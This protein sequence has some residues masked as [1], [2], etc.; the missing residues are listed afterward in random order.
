MKI[1]GKKRREIREALVEAFPMP[2]NLRMVTD[3]VLDVPLQNVTGINNDME[4][5]AFDLIG[6]VSARGRLTELVIGA[7][8]VN[9]DAPKLKTLAAQFQ[10]AQA[11]P[12]EVERINLD[13]VP[14]QNVGQWLEMFARLRRRVCRVERQPPPNTDG[15]GTGFLVAPDVAMTN[16]HVVEPFLTSGAD[17]VRMRFDYET[18]ID[19]VTVSSGRECPLAGSWRLIDSPVKELDFA[20][21]RLAVPAGDDVVAGRKRGTLKPTRHTFQKGHPLIILQHPEAKPL[22]LAIGSV[23]DPDATPNRVSYTVNTEPGSSGSPC[24]TTAL[25]LV[26]LHHW[27]ALPNRGVR[28]GSVL[29][30]LATRQAELKA[31]GLDGLIH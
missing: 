21:V 31:L 27:G 20:L 1:D 7:A 12:G 16:F 26:A 15:Y 3:E 13:G 2:N 25:D 4:T 28:L 17:K 14:F 18:G 22:Q 19:G 24:F 8:A 11:V 30:Y 9:P 23:V 29:D 10:F 5:M 6:W